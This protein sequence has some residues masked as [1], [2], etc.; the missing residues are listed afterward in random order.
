MADAELSLYIR[1]PYSDA[2]VTSFDP[3][4]LYLADERGRYMGGDY[5]D[6]WLTGYIRELG[7]SYQAAYDDERPV[8]TPITLSGHRLLLNVVDSK[9]GIASW[10]ATVDNRFVVFDA[11]EKT[12]TFACE[13]RESWLRPSG[14]THQLRFEVTDNRKNTSIYE[15]TFDY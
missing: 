6:G 14:Q 7:G 10:T 15:A 13:L 9:S 1:R 4:K 11:I 5:H 2:V 8:V 12:T 3:S